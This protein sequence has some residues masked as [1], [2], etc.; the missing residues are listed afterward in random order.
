MRK[1]PADYFKIGPD[2]LLITDAIEGSFLKEYNHGVIKCTETI[3]S[4]INGQ[5]TDDKETFLLTNLSESL[6][7]LIKR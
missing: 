7:Y 2:D 3:D 6:L 4:I 1:D 5:I